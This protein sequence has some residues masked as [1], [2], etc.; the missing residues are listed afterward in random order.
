MTSM[1]H[2]PEVDGVT[3]SVSCAYALSVC[4]TVNV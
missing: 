3:A 1:L 2:E 4:E